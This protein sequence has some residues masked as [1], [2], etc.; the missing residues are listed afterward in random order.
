MVVCALFPPC[1]SRPL[2]IYTGL[3]SLHRL[4]DTS[5]LLTTDRTNVLILLC[6]II[7]SEA[8]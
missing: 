7:L 6:L 3:H 4:D 2:Y 5:A 8:L 1:H